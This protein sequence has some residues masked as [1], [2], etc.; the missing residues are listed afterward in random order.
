M[1]LRSLH[2]LS[3]QALRFLWVE[4]LDFYS[5]AS[6]RDNSPLPFALF[7]VYRFVCAVSTPLNFARIGCLIHRHGWV[8]D[9]FDCTASPC[10]AVLEAR[11]F[12]PHFSDD[13]PPPQLLARSRSV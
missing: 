5:I 7:P 3:P 1:V 13:P 9:Q 12:Y 10:K 2:R 8:N 4:I 11:G 6:L